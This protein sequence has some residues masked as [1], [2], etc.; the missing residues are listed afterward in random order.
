MCGDY[1]PICFHCW[2]LHIG[3]QTSSTRLVTISVTG[4]LVTV[5]GKDWTV[6]YTLYEVLVQLLSS[7]WQMSG[8]HL[9]WP[10][11]FCGWSL[12]KSLNS[13]PGAPLESPLQGPGNARR[14]KGQGS[15][16]WHGRLLCLHSSL[17]Q[18]FVSN[19]FNVPKHPSPRKLADEDL[20]GAEYSLGACVTHVNLSTRL[21]PL[22]WD[23][24]SAKSS[25][26]KVSGFDQQLG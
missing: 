14:L 9:G 12:Q 10:W 24:C 26:P 18:L 2:Y 13:W 20:K 6:E 5:A 16:T 8:F 11:D 7:S 17:W 1:V 21:R 4:L 19:E 3:I 22:G 15:P 23:L 25:T